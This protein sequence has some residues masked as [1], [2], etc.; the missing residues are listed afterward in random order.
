MKTM[1]YKSSSTYKHYNSTSKSHNYSREFIRKTGQTVSTTT[2]RTNISKKGWIIRI[3]TLVFLASLILIYNLYFG[4]KNP[5]S[6][7]IMIYT[8]FVISLSILILAFGWVCYRNP[9]ISPEPY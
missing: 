9:A 6:Q 4:L 3:F 7:P 2:G 1:K 8:G 5:E